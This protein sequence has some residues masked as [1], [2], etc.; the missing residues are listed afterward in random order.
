MIYILWPPFLATVITTNVLGES[1]DSRQL[2]SHPSAWS[3][4][5]ESGVV[6][7]RVSEPLI[8]YVEQKWLE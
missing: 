2:V 6:Q 3:V 5:C 1:S 4:A 7:S 8:K